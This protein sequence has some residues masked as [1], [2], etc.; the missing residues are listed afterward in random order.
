MT[1][2]AQALVDRLSQLAVMAAEIGNAHGCSVQLRLDS[3]GLIVVAEAIGSDRHVAT[4]VPWPDVLLNQGA[5]T[6]AMN[7]MVAQVA[8]KQS[9]A[10]REQ[11]F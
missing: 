6:A 4:D 5:V 9:E 7:A 2:N 11:S 8:Q 3:Y 1:K 10:D